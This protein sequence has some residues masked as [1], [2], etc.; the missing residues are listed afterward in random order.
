MAKTQSNRA[1]RHHVTAAQDPVTAPDPVTAIECEGI[2]PDALEWEIHEYA[3][4]RGP[5]ELLIDEGLIYN[6]YDCTYRDADTMRYACKPWVKRSSLE[7]I[8]AN[9]LKDARTI[10]RLLKDIGG[11]APKT[12]RVTYES[13]RIA[14]INARTY[15]EALEVA[16]EVTKWTF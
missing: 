1:A 7:R 11:A 5:Y 15:E 16:Q 3:T 14:H 8:R 6:G 9:S 12:W 4:K 13:G 10:Y 2:D